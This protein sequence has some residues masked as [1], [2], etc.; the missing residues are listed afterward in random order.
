[1]ADCSEEA[2]SATRDSDTEAERGLL[3]IYGFMLLMVRCHSL[4]FELKDL[5]TA[6]ILIT[7]VGMM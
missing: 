2:K 1:M 7:W 4:T 6:E 5:Y 3:E